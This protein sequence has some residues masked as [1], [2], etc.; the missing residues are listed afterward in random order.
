[1][2]HLE[3]LDY[4]DEKGFYLGKTDRTTIHQQGLWHKTFHCWIFDDK[5]NVLFQLRSHDNFTY[6]NQLDISA[7]GHIKSGEDISDGM[8]ELKEELGID[9][10]FSRLISL[11]EV[12]IDSNLQNKEFVYIYLLRQNQKLK[13]YKLQR[14]ELDGVFSLNVDRALALFEGRVPFEH[15]DGLS[16]NVEN[17]LSLDHRRVTIK[18]FVCHPKEYYLK[19]FSAIKMHSSR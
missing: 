4:F 9:V 8:R 12:V 10:P 13:D 14:S 7:A 6:P 1:M 5:Q 15:I 17:H 2:K 19:V 18:N 3:L 11:G 16:F